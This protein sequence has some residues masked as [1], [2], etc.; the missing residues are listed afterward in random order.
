M[1]DVESDVITVVANAVLTAFP[2]VS[3]SSEY[4]ESVPSLPAVTI[5]ER[6]NSVYQKMRTD[7][8]ENAAVLMYEVAVYSNKTQVAKSEA[9]AIFNVLDE[10]FASVGFTR[11]MRNQ[12]PNYQDQSIH[13]IVARYEGIAGPLGSDHWL[14]YQE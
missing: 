12:I 8:I 7:V 3:V 13:R 2:N 6:D 11:T 4:A 14:I 1:I 10:A 5:E 9:K